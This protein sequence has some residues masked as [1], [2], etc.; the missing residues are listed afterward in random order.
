MFINSGFTAFYLNKLRH[1]YKVHTLS[2]GARRCII[3]P[4]RINTRYNTYKYIEFVPLVLVLKLAFVFGY[5]PTTG[6][7]ISWLLQVPEGDCPRQLNHSHD[8]LQIG[9]QQSDRSVPRQDVGADK[10]RVSISLRLSGWTGN[11]LGRSFL[12]ALCR[13]FV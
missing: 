9:L 3:I 13:T 8:S 6:S 4:Q 7:S 10:V 11:S 1:F 2:I 12:S 5:V